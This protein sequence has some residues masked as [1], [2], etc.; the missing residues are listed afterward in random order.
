MFC[1][2]SHLYMLN[3]ENVKFT[4]VPTQTYAKFNTISINEN[5]TLNIFVFLNSKKATELKYQVT[6]QLQRTNNSA[7]MFYLLHYMNASYEIEITG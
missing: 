5:T 2:V 3:D 4:Y 6:D 1:F 7:L